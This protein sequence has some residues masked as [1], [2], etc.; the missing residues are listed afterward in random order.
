LLEAEESLLDLGDDVIV[1]LLLAEG[2]K[3]DIIVELAGKAVE[4]GERGFELLALAHQA[5]GAAAVAPKVRRLGLAVER[6]QPRPG[7][8]GVKDAS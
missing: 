2:E 7:L 1:T 8:V 3:L 4:G 5:L 6:C